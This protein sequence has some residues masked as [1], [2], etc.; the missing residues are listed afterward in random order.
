MSKLRPRV[1]SL[2]QKIMQ[3]VSMTTV[4]CCRPP[5]SWGPSWQS[6]ACNTVVRALK[7]RPSHFFL[8]LLMYKWPTHVFRLQFIHFFSII[9]PL[10]CTSYTS[11]WPWGSPSSWEDQHDPSRVVMGHQECVHGRGFSSRPTEPR[12]T[13]ATAQPPLGLACLGNYIPMSNLNTT[14]CNP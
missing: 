10:T 6:P 9:Q 5:S 2:L 14:S 12:Q 3:P 7:H 11:P 13:P 4:P 1:R 8:Q